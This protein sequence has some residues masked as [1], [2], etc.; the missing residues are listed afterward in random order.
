M[1]TM[2]ARRWQYPNRVDRRLFSSIENVHRYHKN[3]WVWLWN[4]HVLKDTIMIY[5]GICLHFQNLSGLCHPIQ[6]LRILA[7]ILFMS[8]S[9]SIWTGNE[10]INNFHA[11]VPSTSNY[12]IY[13]RENYVTYKSVA[14]ASWSYWIS[15]IHLK[16]WL[17]IYLNYWGSF[18]TVTIKRS[19]VEIQTWGSLNYWR[20]IASIDFVS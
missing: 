20:E 7:P 13:D 15:C 3:L 4:R 6:K 8:C 12:R 2:Y 11:L 10:L 19:L 5:W 14:F 16:A 9:I 18:C 17:E 1:Q